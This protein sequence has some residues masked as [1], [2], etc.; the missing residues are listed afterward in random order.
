[1]QHSIQLN[2]FVNVNLNNEVGFYHLTIIIPSSYFI[3]YSIL[4]LIVEM[5]QVIITY[6]NNEKSSTYYVNKRALS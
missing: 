3:I 6:S 4:K 2:S 1:M 5:V